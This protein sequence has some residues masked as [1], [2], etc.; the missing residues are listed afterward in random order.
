MNM[1]TPAVKPGRA[2]ERDL[3]DRQAALAIAEQ[4]EATERMKQHHRAAFSGA[5]SC[6][7]VSTTAFDD[8]AAPHAAECAAHIGAD[9]DKDDGRAHW[10]VLPLISASAVVCCVALAFGVPALWHFVAAA[11][12]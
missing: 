9:D 4:R 10:A 7:L 12:R 3:D 6:R 8:Q 1:N 2:T 5:A 11:F